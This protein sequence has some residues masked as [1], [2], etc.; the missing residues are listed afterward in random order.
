MNRLSHPAGGHVTPP[1]LMITD[2]WNLD[3]L[4]VRTDYNDEAAWQIVTAGLAKIWAEFVP[5]PYVVNDPAWAR[6]SADQVL[7]ALGNHQIPVVFL[8]DE[9]TMQADHHGLLAVTTRTPD[10]CED[11]EEWRFHVQFGRQFRIAPDAVA[12]LHCNLALANMDFEEFSKVASEDREAV[13]RG[14]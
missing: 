1:L 4:I 12:S 7:G 13:F 14:F 3:A 5:T 11:D 8:A 2:R 9:V 10:D 6:A